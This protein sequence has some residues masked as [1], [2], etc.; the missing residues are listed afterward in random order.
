MDFLAVEVAEIA[1]P[2]DARVRAFLLALPRLRLV[3]EGDRPPLELVFV[4]PMTS[5][6]S[7]C[8]PVVPNAS[9][10]AFFKR[11][12]MS[13]MARQVMSMPTHLRPS[14]CAA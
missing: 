5:N 8:W 1:D 11:D 4:A 6:W 3:D 13:A 2:V 10:N 12:S 7:R 9:G 14:F